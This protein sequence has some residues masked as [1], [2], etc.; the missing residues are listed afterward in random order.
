MYAWQKTTPAPD[1]APMTWLNAPPRNARG[2][3]LRWSWLLSV[4]ALLLIWHML[5]LRYPVFILPS[6]WLV[7]ER[8]V[9]LTLNGTLPAYAAETLHEA[10]AGLALGG[11]VALVLGF[12]IAQSPFADR[13]LS[14]LIVA[15]QGIPFVAVAPLLFIWFGN[16][17]LPRALMAALIV[18]FPMVVN[19]VSGFRAVPFTLRAVFQSMSATRIEML[20]KLELPAALPFLFAGLRIGITLSVVGAITAEFFSAGR[21]LGYLVSV[22]SGLYDTPLVMA[23]VTAI[24]ALALSLYAAVRLI[25]RVVLER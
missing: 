17:L 20:T 22:G 5:S 9:T 3:L 23:G 18:F 6:P 13:L 24:V 15:T 14:P 7:L 19:V 8:L 25:E 16:G 12:L 10:L 11:A 21:G 4:A 2:Q 1:V